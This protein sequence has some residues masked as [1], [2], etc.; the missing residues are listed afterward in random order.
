[1]RVSVHFP[2]LLHNYCLNFSPAIILEQVL[3]LVLWLN[4]FMYIDMHVRP[5]VEII[6]VGVLGPFPFTK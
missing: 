5:Q 1:M 3:L 2:L 4:V 6:G